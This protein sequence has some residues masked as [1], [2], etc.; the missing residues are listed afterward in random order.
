MSQ[1]L[2][3]RSAIVF[4]P[5]LA[6]APGPAMMYRA[7]GFTARYATVHGAPVFGEPPTVQDVFEFTVLPL[8]ANAITSLPTFACPSGFTIA[9]SPAESPFRFESI[10]LCT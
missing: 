10:P 6:S 8:R 3:G 2:I 5:P 7:F 4:R 1:L 9:R